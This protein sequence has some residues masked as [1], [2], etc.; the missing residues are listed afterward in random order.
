MLARTTDA[1]HYV[2]ASIK[3]AWRKGEVMGALF[4][5]IK[6]AFPSIRLDQLIHNM[7]MRGVPKQY[8][9]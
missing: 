5:D 7:R 4:L 8:T 3:D 6:G 9:N 1:L 2:T